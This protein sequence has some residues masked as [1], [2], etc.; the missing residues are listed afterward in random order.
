MPSAHVI[1]GFMN[2]QSRGRFLFALEIDVI[3]GIVAGIVFAALALVAGR[4]AL[5]ATRLR[6]ALGR[7]LAVAALGLATLAEKLLAVD[8]PATRLDASSPLRP[9][10]QDVALWVG[11]GWQLIKL[12]L[13]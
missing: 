9:A 7:L 10:V 13:N 1:E 12:S 6:P 5:P 2:P 8:E 3:D 4:V 11:D